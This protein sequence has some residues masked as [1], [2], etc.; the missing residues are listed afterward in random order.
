MDI[1]ASINSPFLTMAECILRSHQ[2]LE[3]LALF[4]ATG[5]ESPL[6]CR[7]YASMSQMLGKND[8]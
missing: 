5:P 2:I 7:E 4:P 8:Q 1:V 6:I 3:R